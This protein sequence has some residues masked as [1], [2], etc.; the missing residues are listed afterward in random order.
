MYTGD[1]SYL[2]MKNRF[3]SLFLYFSQH[4]LLDDI[5]ESDNRK[6][7]SANDDGVIMTANQTTTS[8]ANLT[9]TASN[10][11]T[12]P[13]EVPVE[14]VALLSLFYGAIS[15]VAVLGNWNLLVTQLTIA[16]FYGH[17]AT[18]CKG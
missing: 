4:K 15:L 3:N 2:S 11:T 18:F 5:S 8:L 1:R 6:T 7:Y 16:F 12:T 10:E 9:S 14:I 13:Y 17:R